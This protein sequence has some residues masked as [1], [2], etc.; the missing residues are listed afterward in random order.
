MRKIMGSSQKSLIVQFLVETLVIVLIAAFVA[1]GLV[2]TI[3]G[4]GA[5]PVD[6]DQFPGLVPLDNIGIYHRGCYCLCETVSGII[7]LAI[8]SPH[9]H[10][11]SVCHGTVGG[12]QS[13]ENPDCHSIHSNPSTG[14]RNV[15][16]CSKNRIFQECRHGLRW[17]R[18]CR[19]YPA[20]EQRPVIIEFIRI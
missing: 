12:C 15:Y 18:C 2:A 11:K 10:Q 17:K 16:R 6:R 7:G 9:C 4:F 8:R 1:L 14:C 3:V 19:Y 13:E 5:W 20:V